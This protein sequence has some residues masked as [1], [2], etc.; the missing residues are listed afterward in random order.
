MAIKFNNVHVTRQVAYMAGE[1]PTPPAPVYTTATLSKTLD[2]PIGFSTSAGDVFGWSVS[3][4]GNYAVVGA[5]YEDDAGGAQSG[6]AYVFDVATGNLLHTLDNPNAYGTSA[7]DQFSYTLAVDGNYAIVGA[8]YEDDAGGVDSG[9]AYIYDVTTGNLVHTLDN[10]TAFS[11]SAGDNFGE[12][13]AISGNYAIVGARLEDDAGGA[14]SG[15][16]YIFDVTTG[17]LVHTLDNPNV[18]ST[19]L[20]DT[21]GEA[22][23]I[24]GNYAI[25]GASLEDDSSGISSGKAYIFDVTTG[26]LVHQLDNP[27][28]FSTSFADGFGG[29]VSISGNYAIVGAYAE[30]DAGGSGSGK[31]YIFDVTTGNL[32]HTLDNPTA[33]GTSASDEFGYA[34]AISGNYAIVGA[35]AEDDAT[36]ANSGKAYIFDVT[37]GNLVA[38][39]DN[40]NAY[41]PIA[42]L[43]DQFGRSVSI[44]GNYAI[45][46][47]QYEDDASGSG[48][49]KAYIFELS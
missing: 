34:V 16:A 37:T 14:A 3:I 18:F 20:N 47:A 9:K 15:K 21:F 19:S 35:Y 38:T 33:F 42:G 23:S 6:K 13:V 44:S 28:A 7:N 10:P 30:D 27:N 2:D 24:S 5:P 45:V 4:S 31:A 26:N 48:S 22:V 17:N 29:S 12:S 49:G 46:G 39:L 25:V 41:I 43:N 11:T 8:Y 40:P 1:L 32:L 36:G